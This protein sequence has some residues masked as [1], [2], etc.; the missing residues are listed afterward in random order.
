MIHEWEAVGTPYDARLCRNDLIWYRHI[1]EPYKGATMRCRNG[2]WAGFLNGLCSPEFTTEPEAR[3]WV[4]KQIENT[5]KETQEETNE[6]MVL[7]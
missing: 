1:S 4:E 2:G 5:Y 6:N 7:E 3:K